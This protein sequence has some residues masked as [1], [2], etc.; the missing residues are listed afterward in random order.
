M[1]RIKKLK[2]IELRKEKKSY[3]QIAKTLD[4]SKGTVSYWLS[5]LDWSKNIEKQLALRAR[6]IS[7]KR[8]EHLNNLKKIKWNRI[9][10]KA[11]NEAKINFKKLKNN[12]LF[13]LGIAAYWGEGDKNFVN[14]RVRI[15]NIDSELL[16]LFK[17]F[18]I[19]ICGIDRKKIKGNVLIYPDLDSKKCVSYWSKKIGI[20]KSNFYGP[21]RI[22]G[23]HKTR[24]IRYGV[25][26]IQ[27]SDKYLKK[28]ILIW[29][30]L[31]SDL[32]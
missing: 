2:A 32:F 6:E 19:E 23:R 7:K 28:K 8:L 18:L 5:S 10:A 26:S 9:Y 11:E 30:G 29:I 21:V 17:N 27:V 22:K 25:C 12:P 4:V 15:S 14:G 16:R 20:S 3:N 13:L 24:R 31:L 1:K